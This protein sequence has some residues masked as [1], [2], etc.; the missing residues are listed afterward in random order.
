MLDFRLFI[1]I[2]IKNINKNSF[3]PMFALLPFQNSHQC[4]LKSWKEISIIEKSLNY[5]MNKNAFH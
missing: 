3:K 2:N 5:R 4:V 1:L